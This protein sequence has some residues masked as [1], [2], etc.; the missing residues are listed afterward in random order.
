MSRRNDLR[1]KDRTDDELSAGGDGAAD[2]ARIDHGTGAEQKAFGQRRCQLG[3]ELDGAW[4][5]HRDFKC[6]NA[7]F[8][9]R[10][11]HTVERVRI[12]QA[13]DGHDAELF[14]GFRN[15]GSQSRRHHDRGLIVAV[16]TGRRRR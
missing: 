8:G 4:H 13:D 12:L 10:L 9:E 6:A 16:S 5:R 14:N 1:P 7:A 3:D 11:N 15:L 2:R